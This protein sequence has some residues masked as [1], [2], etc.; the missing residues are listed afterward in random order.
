MQSNAEVAA[1][2]CAVAAALTKKIIKIIFRVI[3]LIFTI[4]CFLK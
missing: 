4:F 2:S 1:I 3:Q